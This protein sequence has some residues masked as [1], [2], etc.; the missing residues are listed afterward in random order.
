MEEEMMKKG[1]IIHCSG[2]ASCREPN[3]PG[4]EFQSAR[5]V[6]SFMLDFLDDF[7]LNYIYEI[8]LDEKIH[9]HIATHAIP[10][11]K[12]D[13]KARITGLPLQ[14]VVKGYYLQDNLSGNVYGLMIPGNKNYDRNKIASLIGIP[15][16]EAE[17]R[18]SRSKWLPVH[19]VEGTVHPW[20]NK[21]CFKSKTGNGKLERIA[22]DSANLEI[23]KTEGGLDDFSFTTP[24]DSG[25]DNYRLSLQMNYHDAFRILR[26]IFKDR[27]ISGDIVNNH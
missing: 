24:K 10:T 27:I 8:A 11:K 19:I 5:D 9:F 7:N 14:R 26:E 21:D 4:Y 22:F 17:K 12:C 16:E 3:E 18:I 1:R 6:H 25:Y 13:E 20:V 15:P 23:R 2:I